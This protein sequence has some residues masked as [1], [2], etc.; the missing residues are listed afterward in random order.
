MASCASGILLII[1][2]PRRCQAVKGF[3]QHITS[4]G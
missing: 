3:G 2:N 4:T 1:F